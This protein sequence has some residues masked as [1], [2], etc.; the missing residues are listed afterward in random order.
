LFGIL[1]L[2][3]YSVGH[4]FLILIAGTSAGF[5]K[6]LSVSNKYGKVSQTLKIIMEI[7]I[8]LIAFYMFYLAF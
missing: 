8:L 6:H 1:L 3:L 5:V 4:S 7:I 2:L